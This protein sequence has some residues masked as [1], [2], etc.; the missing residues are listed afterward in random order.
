M[1]H[2]CDYNLTNGINDALADMLAVADPSL[3]RRGGAGGTAHYIF[4]YQMQILAALH[5]NTSPTEVKLVQPQWAAFSN[6]DLLNLMTGPTVPSP[7]WLDDYRDMPLAIQLNEE[8][9]VQESNADGAGGHQANTLLWISPPNWNRNLPTGPR[10]Q[11][12]FTATIAGLLGAW[13]VDTNITPPT[14]LQ[15]GNYAVVGATIIGTNLIAA[16]LNFQTAPTYQGIK[17]LP[18]GIAAQSFTGIQ[19]QKGAAWMGEWG[20][21]NTYMLPQVSGLASAAG[22]IATTLRLDCVYLGTSGSL[23]T[24]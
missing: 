20:R 11:L 7:V 2:L 22:N 13:S 18:G 17:M 14:V 3:T 16:R 10:V 8:L 15:G 23:S 1:F 24:L 4:P 9:A 21:F 5:L 12:N 6:L 19:L